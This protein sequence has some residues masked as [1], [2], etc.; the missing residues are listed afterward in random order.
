[1]LYYFVDPDKWP[2]IEGIAIRPPTFKRGIG[3]PR[4]SRRRQADEPRPTHVARGGKR[5]KCGKCGQL[6]HNI[7]SCTNGV[8][9]NAYAERMRREADRANLYRQHK[10]QQEEVGQT[11]GTKTVPVT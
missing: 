2:H 1:M 7:R 6:G 8:T 9:D 10:K 3:R 11:S 4:K 5:S